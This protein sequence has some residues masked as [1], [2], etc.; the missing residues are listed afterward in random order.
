MANIHN[1]FYSSDPNKQTLHRRIIPNQKQREL[2]QERWNDLCDYL[3][4]DLNEVSGYTISSWLQG[5][6]KFGTQ[7]RPAHKG[8][9]FDIDLGVYFN[10][11]GNPDDGKFSPRGLKS[12]VQDSLLRYKDEAEDVV[13]VVTPPEERCSRIRFPGDFHIDVPSYHLDEVRD[14]RALATESDNWEYSDP[15]AIYKWFREHYSDEESSQVRRII[16]YVKIWASLQLKE[17][18]SSILLTVLVAEAY[19][20][21]ID[22]EVDGDDSALRHVSDKIVKRL[23]INP[24]VVNPVDPDE[25]LNRLTEE[26]TNTLVGKLND[27]VDLA[28]RALASSTEFGSLVAFQRILSWFSYEFHHSALVAPYLRPP[29]EYQLGHKPAESMR[30]HS[31]NLLSQS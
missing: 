19:L 15:K 9:E 20:E 27:L 23:E 10:W 17:P 11:T 26:E 13:E 29:Y 12:L 24:Q 7:V 6:Y 2:Q 28:D 25:N 5:S 18:P 14:A 4:G 21:L 1:L 30:Q 8:G 31:R 16:R 3:I 22:Q